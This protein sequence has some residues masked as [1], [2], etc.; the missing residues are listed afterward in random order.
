MISK[1][2]K[3][4][5]FDSYLPAKLN[6]NQMSGLDNKDPNNKGGNPGIDEGE[7][8]DGTIIEEGYR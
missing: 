6:A 8:K 1:M 2:E 5:D 7:K 3:V 4:L